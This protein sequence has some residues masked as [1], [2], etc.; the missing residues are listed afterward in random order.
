MTAGAPSTRGEPRPIPAIVA[1]V[2]AVIALAQALTGCAG[3]A[4]GAARARPSSP[5]THAAGTSAPSAAAA[6]SRFRS[7]RT[8]AEV[9]VP[10]RLRIPSIGVD[11]RLDQV[12]LDPDGT[13]AAPTSYQNA[14]WYAGGPKP[15]ERGPAI[16]LGHV[17][18]KNT[19]PAVFFKVA[20]LKEGAEVLVDRKDGST[21]RFRV[22]GRIQ[23]AKDRFP[24]NIV[25]GPTLAPSLRLV[26][27]GGKFNYHTNH[28][29]DN[30]VVTAV[31]EV[32]S[33]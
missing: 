8:P 21:V 3:A 22:S 19:G 31:P 29:L 26:T 12:G 15:G 20:T 18:S 14:A 6:A 5:S 4:A 11:A 32:S 17:D 24:A 28:Y 10:V 33:P 16:L 23:V 2:V 13:I 27:C 1:V 30:I 25:Y 7:P 9:A